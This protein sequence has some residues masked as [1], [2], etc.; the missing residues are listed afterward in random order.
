MHDIQEFKRLYESG[1]SIDKIAD[2]FGL[3]YKF[4]R[5][6]L[7]KSGTAMRPNKYKFTEEQIA[8]IVNKYTTNYTGQEIAKELGCSIK[9]IKNVIIKAGVLWDNS[10][11]NFKLK[12]GYKINRECFKN[13]DTE[14]EL[15]FYGLL[16]ADGCIISNSN[17][18]Q[19]TTQQ[20]DKAIIESLRDF[21]GT[22]KPIAN[23]RQQG[24]YESVALCFS[25]KEI[26]DKLRSVGLESRKSLKEK[27]PTF[28]NSDDINMRHF[29]RGFVDGDGSVNS[30]ENYR[31]RM[32]GL[33][34]TKEI[35]DDFVAF[36]KKHSSFEKCS[37]VQ[38]KVVNKNCYELCAN[39][40]DASA[41][42]D[43]LYKDSNFHID[44]KKIEADQLSKLVGV[45]RPTPRRNKLVN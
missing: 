30:L 37:I 11:T 38:N 5:T 32:V 6:R 14:A 17:S 9:V 25:D 44:R 1:L 26:A 7:L 36:C 3:G 21:I 40:K 2:K 34:G 29:W 18:I 41:I 31:A 22:D 28:Y 42:A 15:Y 4:V 13:F 8:D 12:N 35:I 45:T 20:R 43:L 24:I 39:G 23:K 27:V 10:P 19:I 33:I 16:L